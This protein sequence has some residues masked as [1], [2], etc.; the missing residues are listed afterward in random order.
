MTESAI[1]GQWTAAPGAE[2]I[3]TGKARYCPDI[4]LPGLLCG[5]LLYSPHARARIRKLDV[6]KA[7]NMPGVFAVI[8]HAD[9]PG[10]NSYLYAEP[11][12]PLLV[13]DEVRFQGDAVAAVAAVDERTDR[14]SV[15]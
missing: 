2:E 7:R 5:K 14:K 1:V 4:Q 10:E 3:V 6:R 15:V 11:D 12:Q 13:V 8:T 9:I